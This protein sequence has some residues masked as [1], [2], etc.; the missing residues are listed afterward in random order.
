MNYV[1]HK[2][3]GAEWKKANIENMKMEDRKESQLCCV[4]L[5][6]TYYTSAVFFALAYFHWIRLIFPLLV[7]YSIYLNYMTS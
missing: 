4:Q 3:A 6:T 1:L 5:P 7:F 2:R